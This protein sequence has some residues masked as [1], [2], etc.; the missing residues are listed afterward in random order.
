MLNVV[1]NYSSVIKC[2]DLNL[3][4]Q[5]ERQIIQMAVNAGMTR[6]VEIFLKILHADWERLDN[7]RIRIPTSGHQ[8]S[9][10]AA[11]GQSGNIV[12]ISSKT[13]IGKARKVDVSD[14]M[15]E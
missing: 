4:K 10:Q 1:I 2:C 6:G 15:E 9:G 14:D 7:L 5:L 11:F 12:D 3:V 8:T 13:I